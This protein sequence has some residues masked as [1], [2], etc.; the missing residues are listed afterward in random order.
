MVA[1]LTTACV[2]V[3][4]ITASALA[5]GHDLTP[6]DGVCE[7]TA[8]VGDCSLRAAV[9]EA[10]AASGLV[11]I[12]LSD[13][14][15][16][17]TL[18]GI[19]DDN[20]GGDL[21]IL[22][23]VSIVSASGFFVTIDGN[24]IDRVA[25]VRGN[26]TFTEV[27][28]TG[29]S[30]PDAGGGI[31]VS[32]GTLQLTRSRV[33]GNAGGSFGGGVGVFFGFAR[34]QQSLLDNNMS[35]SGGGLGLFEGTSAF[36]EN[37][38][39][40]NN[41]ADGAGSGPVPGAGGGVFNL[42]SRLIVTY[43]TIRNNTAVSGLGGGIH[44]RELGATVFGGSSLS[45]HGVAADCVAS[46]AGSNTSGGYSHAS[47]ATC[48]AGITDVVG[49]DP[50]LGPLGFN[51]GPTENFEPGPASPLIDAIPPVG[52]PPGFCDGTVPA[53]QSGNPRPSDT[54]CEIGA[55]ELGSAT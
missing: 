7:M 37:S 53:D 9:D 21:D 27:T 23:D 42:G 8:G 34:I 11:Q 45:A 54:G 33:V 22:G 48:F 6:G 41:T 49:V 4:T 14:A 40:A 1:G 43:S 55:R 35:A 32:G 52:A 50:T 29:G 12:V 16:E 28:I 2:P 39:I 19:D 38:T 31:R 26:A 46:A 15:Y 18:P 24:G 10:N 20:T 51:G 30:T 3:L 25:D 5:D 47:D 17:L 44:S 13:G 36:V